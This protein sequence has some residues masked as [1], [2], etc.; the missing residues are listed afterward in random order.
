VKAVVQL[1]KQAFA[2]AFNRETG[3]PLW[4]IEERPV[5]K[6]DVPGEWTSPT[7]PF[8]TKPK[9]YDRQGVTQADLV[10]FTPEIKAAALAA[11]K[12][13]RMGPMFTPPSLINAPDGTRGAL[14]LPHF[15]GGSNWEGGAADPDTGMLYAASQMT[16][17]VF[18]VDEARD[19][20]DIRYL[21]V[22]GDAPHPLGLPLIKPPYGRITAID[23]N[24]GEHRWM[25]PNGDTPDDIKNNPALKG[26]T[27]PPTGKPSKALL[28]VTKTLLFAGE[29]YGGAP[30]LRAYDKA[31]GK[32]IAELPLPG[33]P[34]GKPMSYLLNGKQYI[35]LA[36]GKQNPAE[37][38]ALALP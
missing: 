37:L 14:V 12:D 21:F 33:T 9:G 3:E 25:V 17:N 8:P 32:V 18:A 38:V 7:Q 16:I 24:T 13:L 34:S 35:V 23:M 22:N 15:G 30:I 19:R 28:L 6:S 2:Y 4:P 11:V 20:S 1:T 29:G 36:V 31:T 26:V 5:P 27:L 10:D